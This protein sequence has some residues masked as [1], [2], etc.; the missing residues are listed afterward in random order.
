MTDVSPLFFNP[1]GGIRRIVFKSD[2]RGQ[3][4]LLHTRQKDV[5]P[6]E[7]FGGM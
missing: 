3:Q 7:A 4:T 1:H 6:F 5:R 2:A